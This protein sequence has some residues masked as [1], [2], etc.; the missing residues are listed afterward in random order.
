LAISPP[1]MKKQCFSQAF[2]RDS[3]NSTDFVGFTFLPEK[4]LVYSVFM[5]Y[6][7]QSFAAKV[8]IMTI[9][10]LASATAEMK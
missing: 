9:A 1:D 2:V 8:K 6:D 7:N 4:A 5:T 3:F 10:Q